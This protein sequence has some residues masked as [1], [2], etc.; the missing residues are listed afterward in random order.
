LYV[1]GTPPIGK[2]EPVAFI[3]QIAADGKPPR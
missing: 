1:V 3:G 2:G